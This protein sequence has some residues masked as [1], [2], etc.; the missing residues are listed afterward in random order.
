MTFQLLLSILS[1][2][3]T[4]SL[5]SA[6]WNHF[7]KRKLQE[8]EAATKVALENL[9]DRFERSQRLEQAAIDRSV[10]VTRAHFETEFEAMKKVF[11]RLALLSMEMA[12][13]RT[14]DP[15]ALAIENLED[16][17]NNFHERLSTVGT[18]YDALLAETEA[19][20]PFY[21]AEVYRALQDCLFVVQLE[22]DANRLSANAL[23]SQGWY[24]DG[25]SNLNKFIESY[26]TV[27]TV[28]R[29]RM[30]RLSILPTS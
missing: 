29:E 24:S 13:L 6:L 9:K 12:G 5:V 22:I 19:R 26:N 28:I 17:T 3:I 4:G 8:D 7:S 18:L 1:S 16:E 23:F 25:E 30:S 2:G 21:S 27:A 10:F 20:L 11:E 15:V 14:I